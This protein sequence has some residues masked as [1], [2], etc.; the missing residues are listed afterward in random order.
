MLQWGFVA[1][2]SLFLCRCLIISACNAI[3]KN[4]KQYNHSRLMAS[5]D[6]IRVESALSSSPNNQNGSCAKRAAKLLPPQSP[7]FD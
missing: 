4:L 1:V 2:G 7:K 5:Q 6:H 3:N